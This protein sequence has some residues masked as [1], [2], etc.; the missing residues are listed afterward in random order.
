[1][2]KVFGYEHVT[3]LVVFIIFMSLSLSWSI[4]KF[5]EGKDMATYFKIGGA[6]LLFAIIWNRISIAIG[7]EDVMAILP[8]S[9]CGLSSLALALGLILL[10]KDHP[11]FHSVAYMG[12]IGG[13]I[14]LIYPDFISQSDSV[15]YQ[16]TISGLIHHALVTWLAIS[17]IVHRYIN[18]SWSMWHWFPIGLSFYMSYGLFLVTILNLENAMLIN[19]PILPG[20]PLNWFVMGILVFIVHALLLTFLKGLPRR[21]NVSR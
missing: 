9:F 21:E 17:M 2:P 7:T 11:Y 6:C 4:K 18:P 14:T 20:T 15:F 8:D 19:E 16:M 13:I 12:L 3:F 10:R 5:R 1:M